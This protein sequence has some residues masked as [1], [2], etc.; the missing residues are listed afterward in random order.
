MIFRIWLKSTKEADQKKFIEEFNEALYG[1]KGMY[2]LGNTAGET[3]G[4][5]GVQ[6][7]L[8][9]YPGCCG[10][11]ILSAPHAYP[12][13][14]ISQVPY[15]TEEGGIAYR[16]APSN[17][18]TKQPKDYKP[19]HDPMQYYAIHEYEVC[20]F[21]EF[22]IMFNNVLLEYCQGGILVADWAAMTNNLTGWVRAFV[23]PSKFAIQPYGQFHNH[24]TGRELG[25]WLLVRKSSAR[26]LK[27][28]EKLLS[29]VAPKL[30]PTKEEEKESGVV[31][32]QAA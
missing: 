11:K 4:R 29:L 30:E 6:F 12:M 2:S 25:L 28:P 31:A 26:Y 7:Q 23:S 17:Q 27:G 20:S 19:A 18:F 15:R 24:N 10:L 8:D 22:K 13:L 32:S 5:I 14:E 3:L 9:Y 16:T 1:K 21:T